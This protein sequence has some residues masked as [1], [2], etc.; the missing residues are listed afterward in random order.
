MGFMYTLYT[1]MSYSLNLL[2][3]P[4]ITP[5][6][7]PYIVP[8]ITPFKEC[9]LYVPTWNL[10]AQQLAYSCSESTDYETILGSLPR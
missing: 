8:Y 3:F 4:L 2:V 9:T 10:G 5:T 6:V 1:Y 7:V